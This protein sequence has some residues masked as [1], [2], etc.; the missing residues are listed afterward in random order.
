MLL[1]NKQSLTNYHLLARLYNEFS[2]S[3]LDSD[4]SLLLSNPRLSTLL[5]Y[6]GTPF[7]APN[8]CVHHHP[9]I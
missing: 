8:K 3:I 4:G 2:P 5:F 6:I 1:P 7:I 9:V